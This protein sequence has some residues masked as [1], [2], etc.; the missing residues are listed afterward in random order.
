MTITRHN[1]FLYTWKT[2]KKKFKMRVKENKEKNLLSWKTK[3]MNTYVDKK[4][5][6][7]ELSMLVLSSDENLEKT[8]IDVMLMLDF[9]KILGMI[10]SIL[11]R[12]FCLSI[13]KS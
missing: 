8:S 1:K 4:Y 10:L 11:S 7:D 3:I 12:K 2:N 13:S 6:I 9:L 5:S